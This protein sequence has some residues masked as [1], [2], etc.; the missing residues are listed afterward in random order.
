MVKRKTADNIISWCVKILFSTL[1]VLFFISF[2]WIEGTKKPQEEIDAILA[3]QRKI[4][5][6][7]LAGKDITKKKRIK[8]GVE[9]H[10]PPKM[11]HPYPDI[12]LL[13]RNGRSFKISN[14]K[15]YVI[16]ISYVDM[17]SPIS[18]AQ[19][20]AAV[21]GPYGASK[22]IDKYSYTFSETVRKNAPDGFTL[23]KNGVLEIN[24]LVY[25][26]NG[27]QATLDDADKW[28]KHFN[29]SLKRGVLVVV[30][31][32]DIRGKEIQNILTGYQLID[33]NMI[34]RVD[35]A[36][37]KPK[38]NLSMTLVPLLSKLIR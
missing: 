26:Q 24:V 8:D 3:K 14:L 15:G 22:K 33:Q 21:T 36:G 29:L 9:Y 1:F 19:A 4:M 5:I 37:Y 34:L 27:S 11:N 17:S 28:A 12:A 7:I 23:P 10:W 30:P 6:D 32:Q 31:K 35:S 13:D 20:G 25:S 18:Q 38:H 16:V 2:I